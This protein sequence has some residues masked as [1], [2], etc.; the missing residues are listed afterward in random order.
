MGKFAEEDLPHDWYL[1]SKEQAIRM[2]K[3]LAMETCAE[4]LLYGKEVVVIA[5]KDGRDDF[6]FSV[7]G[8]A[9]PLYVVHLTWSKET[10]PE[11]PWVTPFR[12]KEDFLE[13][14]RRIYD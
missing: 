2:K 7:S 6:L 8:A 3:E 14:W 12:N 9:S 13:N 1:L 10:K 11:W 4:H 5:R